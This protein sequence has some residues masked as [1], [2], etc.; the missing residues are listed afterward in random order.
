MKNAP[1]Q[2]KNANGNVIF[3]MFT[4]DLGLYVEKY[5]AL[6]G[7]LNTA[8]NFM[9]LYGFTVS[10]VDNI[11]KYANIRKYHNY[12]KAQLQSINGNLSN[13]ARA[14]LRQRFVTGVRF[15]NS[16]NVSYECENYENWLEE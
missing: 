9:N 4:T 11:K 16:D 10:A 13:V 2:L 6:E 8:N 1:D 3:N 12:I 15:W 5:S 7:D 14:D